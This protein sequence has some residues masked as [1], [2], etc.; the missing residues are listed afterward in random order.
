MQRK[1][2]EDIPLIA[3]LFRRASFGAPYDQLE[4]YAAKGYQAAVEELLHPENQPPLEEDLLL[5]LEMGWTSRHSGQQE[6][7]YWF[8]RLINTCRPLEEKMALF[9]HG[10][11][12][13]GF[14][15][16]DHSRQMGVTVGMFRRL[17]LGSFRDLLIEL[18][19]DPGMIYYLD[20]CISHKGAINENWGRELLELFSMGVGNYT[21]DDVK[22]ASRAFTGWT[23]SPT[24]PLYP[25]G[26]SN[27]WDFRYD[28]TDHD[29]GDKLFLGQRGQMNGE[30]IIDTI[31]QQPATARFLARQLYNFFVSDEP[32]VPQWA[33]TPPKEP[34]AIDI[35][36]KAYF[37]YHYDLR[38][39][40]RVL[41]NSDFFR[42]ARFA[43]VKSP[44]E[45]VV[46]TV[47]LAK[48]LDF[49]S[50]DLAKVV[51][52]CGYMGQELYNPPSVEGWHTGQEWIDSGALVERVNFLAEEMGD[53][54]KPGVCQMVERL[55]ARG[56]SFAP[57][58]LV[59][60]CLD[61]LGGVGLRPETRQTLLE[62]AQHGGPISTGSQEF[63]SRVAA[64]LRII[65][66]TKEY[67]LN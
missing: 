15:K 21:E 44:A 24:L 9:W 45:L 50:P 17:G 6:L 42:N 7:S 33:N 48:D 27:T 37:E 34:E 11:L 22:E 53:T 52:Q 3:H 29:H 51:D 47:R 4:A 61:E 16:V 62:F 19:R 28:P 49:P 32:P 2:K 67:Q 35:L 25:Y 54:T 8:Y 59:D 43:K 20:N 26:R 12:C 58:E 30:D 31:C 64:I 46:G 41:F 55:G 60:G 18:A 13:T 63:A 38:S 10:L 66:A 65:V 14:S 36:V 1:T 40:L 39:I 23:N 57:E 56:K 5:R